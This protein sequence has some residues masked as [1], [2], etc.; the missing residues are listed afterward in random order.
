VYV[1]I[2]GAGLAGLSCALELE[3][4]GIGTVIYEKNSYIGEQNPNVGAILEISHR[5]IKDSLK[6]FRNEFGIDIKP[7]NT[8]NRVIHYSQNNVTEIK[9]NFGYFIKRNKDLDDIKNQL[10]SKLK[11]T[12]ILFNE[13]QDYQPLSKKY[14]YVV[15]ANG[16]NSFSSELGCWIEDWTNTYVYGAAALGDFDPNTFI[17][18]VNK[19]YCKNGYAYLAPFDSKKAAIGLVI[20]DVNEREVEYFW[21]LFLYTENIKY[22]FVEEFK[23]NHKSG[24]VYPHRVGNIFLAGNA[25]GALDP[26]LGFGIMNSISTG[27]MAARSIAGGGDYEKLIKSFMKRNIQFYEFRKALNITSNSGYDALIASLGM[28]GIKHVMYYTPLNVVRYGSY[29]LKLIRKRN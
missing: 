17:V 12:R 3:K 28:P 11:N 8:I 2:I 5:P 6:Y 29:I 19:N 22:S 16:D 1:A 26:F 7:L 23:L 25:G 15:I 24:Y 13:Y 10:Y 20:T 18:W 21:K 27:V 14:D 4:H 9:G